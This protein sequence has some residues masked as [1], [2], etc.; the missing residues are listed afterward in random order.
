VP[1]SVARASKLLDPNA[2]LGGQFWDQVQSATN[3]LPCIT[4]RNWIV[5]Q[6]ATVRENGAELY[7]LD[8]PMLVKS[9]P[10]SLSTPPGAAPCPNQPKEITDHN[11][12]VFEKVILPKITEAVNTAPEYEDL[13]RVYLSR[14]IATW[15][16]Q[17]SAARPNAYTPI[18]NS[19]DVS[20]WPARTKWNPQDVYQAYLK[21]Y[22]DG[23]YTYTWTRQ[24]NGKTVTV[25]I[26]VGGVDFS[27]SPRQ[28]IDQTTFTQKWPALPQ[29][30]QT[31]QVTLVADNDPGRTWMGATNGPPPNQPSNPPAANPPPNNGGLPITGASVALTSGI[32]ATL[33]AVGAALVLLI[34]R[35][36]PQLRA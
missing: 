7:V 29:T 21:S 23:E 32:G 5:P 19:G 9:A 34:R 30:V 13:R 31:S 6:P 22:K 35:R 18:I 25:T 36:R 33:L 10:I 2:P 12:Q 8:A 4:F 16:R 28:P 20:R 17:R 11:Q 14:V 24:Q 3:D 15:L 1:L 26:V 27:E